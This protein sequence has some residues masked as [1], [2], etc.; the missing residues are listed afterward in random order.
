MKI[1]NAVKAN[2][3]SFEIMQAFPNN[4]INFL[5]PFVL[6]HH[7]HNYFEGGE[8]PENLGVPPHPHRGFVPV[9]IILKGALHHRDSLGNSSIINAGGVQ[10]TSSGSGLVHSERPTK[11]L[12]ENGG[13]LE[14]IQLW[15]NLP[16]EDKMN[17]PE[18]LAWEDNEIPKYIS[19]GTKISII[20][21]KYEDKIGVA[22][23]KFDID[24]LLV[25]IKDN[26]EFELKLD[27]NK[28]TYIY[29]I[30]GNLIMNEQTLTKNKLVVLDKVSS[31]SISVLNNA[32]LL[33][34]SGND[35]GEH[36]AAMGPFVMNSI[37][38][39]KKAFLDYNQGLFGE[40]IE[41]F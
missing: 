6:L 18:Y 1:Y 39:A 2:M 29:I 7:A 40:L 34:M 37:G 22:K 12:S 15:V 10:W 28:D 14:L 32:K 21:G 13:E 41:K 38:E 35:N 25:E 33:V 17:D 5:N 11:E 20:S 30:A 26:E 24:L 36:V 8:K 23:S 9:S 16:K 19:N 4:E 3:D 31:V 27:E